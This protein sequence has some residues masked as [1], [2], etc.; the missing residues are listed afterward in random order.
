RLKATGA[1]ISILGHITKQELL[2]DLDST[3]AANGFGNRFLWICVR[4]SKCLPKG[5]RHPEEELAPLVDRLQAALEAARRIGL[6]ERD[7]D[8]E[9]IWEEVY[10]ELSEGKPGLM[11]A[12]IARAEAQVM[13]LAL[14]YALLDGSDIIRREHMLAA[15]AVWEYYEASARFI[16]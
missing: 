6:M 12:M 2:R 16:F 5:G 14:L 1:H 13:R 10:P 15:L 4:R 8:A 11:G 3:S 9:A 7:A